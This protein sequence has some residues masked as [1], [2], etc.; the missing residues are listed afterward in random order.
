LLFT[1]SV[2]AVLLAAIGIYGVMTCRV[3]SQIRELA[4]RQALGAEPR[5]VIAHVIHQGLPILI[6]GVSGGLLGTLLLSRLLSSVLVGVKATDPATLTSVT[7][8]VVIV[9]LAA[10]VVPAVRASRTD[11]LVF[12]RQD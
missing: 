4:V 7:A 9:A 5:D 12:L 2:L 8:A 11:P 10:S 1:F 6:F 3:R